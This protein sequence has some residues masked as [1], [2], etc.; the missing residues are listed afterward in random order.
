MPLGG[1]MASMIS[2]GVSNLMT[3]IKSLIGFIGAGKD[4]KRAL[5]EKSKLK[6]PFYK[7][8]DEYYQNRNLAGN[9]AGQGMPSAI[10]DYNLMENERGFSSGIGAIQQAGGSASDIAKLYSGFTDS[11]NRVGVEDANMQLKNIGY[12]MNANKD[13][14]GQKTMQW[15]INDYS[16]YQNK[17][18]EITKRIEAAKINKNNAMNDMIGSIGAAG[19]AMQNKDQLNSI[20][21]P[22]Q[23][24]PFVSP[25]R[26]M[27]GAIA[28]IQSGDFRQ[29]GSAINPGGFTG[30]PNQQSE[31]LDIFQLIRSTGR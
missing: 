17:L 20:L 5:E 21:T 11:L 12:F 23:P 14:A 6:T 19:T 8:Q 13:V 7:I 15:T 22:S 28:P 9:M 31:P 1:Q 4:E 29:Q 2:S 26:V 24:D 16:P 25:E 18:K 30:I 10:R 3:P 27:G